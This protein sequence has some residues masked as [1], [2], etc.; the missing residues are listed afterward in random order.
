MLFISFVMQRYEKKLNLP[1]NFV[2]KSGSLTYFN[3]FLFFNLNSLRIIVIKT[4]KN[5]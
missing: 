5:E 2:K 1:N 4:I 3:N